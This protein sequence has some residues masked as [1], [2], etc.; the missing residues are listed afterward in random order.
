MEFEIAEQN[1]NVWFGHRLDRLPLE[2]AEGHVGVGSLHSLWP[3]CGGVDIPAVVAESTVADHA[4]PQMLGQGILGGLL[5][6]HRFGLGLHDFIELAQRCGLL[7]NLPLDAS[8]EER[9]DVR[10]KNVDRT[11]EVVVPRTVGDVENL[12]VRFR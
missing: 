1:A 4:C 10:N 8:G 6:G 12:E 2:P 3:F 5:S 7:L 11:A 9:L